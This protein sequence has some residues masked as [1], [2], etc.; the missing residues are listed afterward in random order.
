MLKNIWIPVILAV[1]IILAL[2]ISPMASKSPDGLERVA[3]D[4]GFDSHAREGRGPFSQYT[5]PGVTLAKASTALSGLMGTLL[6]FGTV[7]LLAA[8][9]R[10][11]HGSPR[12]DT[13]KSRGPKGENS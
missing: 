8:L 5:L 7:F 3:R 13:K 10:G 4:S 6:A 12:G 9:L 11:R 2:F 1:S